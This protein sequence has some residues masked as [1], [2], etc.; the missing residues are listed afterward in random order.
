MSPSQD[1]IVSCDYNM[2]EAD[3]H[4]LTALLTIIFLENHPGFTLDKFQEV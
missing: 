4:Q 1:R 3:P 2:V